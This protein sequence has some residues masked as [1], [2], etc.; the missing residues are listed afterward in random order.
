M[1][2]VL[3]RAKTPKAAANGKRE[4]VWDIAFFFPMQ[5]D[6]TE[7][8]YLALERNNG[9][10]MIELSDGFL[11]ILPMPDLFHQRIVKMLCRRVDDFILPQKLG[12]TAVAPLPIRL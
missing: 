4:P 2:S 7:Q 5:G 3:E 10:W 9:N 1:A 8:D 11:E 12:E 6:W